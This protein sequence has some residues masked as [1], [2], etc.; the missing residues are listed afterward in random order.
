MKEQ[1][2]W[3]NHYVLETDAS[4]VERNIRVTDFNSADKN[5]ELVYFEKSKKAPNVLISQGSGGHA[6]VFAELGYRMHLKG[7]N[8]FIMPKHGG[9][10]IAELMERHRDAL[11]HISD[12]YNE[13]TGV[14]AEGLGGYIV[15]YLA[16]AHGTF[17]S[18]V[19]QNSPALLTEKKFRD[20]VIRGRRRIIMP[21]AKFLLAISPRMNF[22]ISSYLNWKELIDTKETNREVEFHLVVDGYLNDPD[23]D[24]KYPLS[25]IMSLLLTPPP[26][27]LTELNIPTMF[28]VAERGFGGGSYVNYLEELY[29]RLPPIKKEITRIDGGVYWMLSHPKEAANIICNWFHQTLS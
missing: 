6:Y 22:P 7:Y 26:N 28:M 9:Y 21:V 10:T 4:E 25:A 29:S 16:L 5:F 18:A 2:Y 11:K 23:F 3:K 20:A 27:Q 14:F 15:F 12:N 1:S 24:K 19:Y 13:R 8:V 17:K